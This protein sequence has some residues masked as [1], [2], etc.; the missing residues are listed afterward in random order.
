MSDPLADPRALELLAAHPDEVGMLAAHFR[1]AASESQATAT[2]LSAARQECTWIG[3]AADAFRRAIGRLPA[4]L[5]RVSAG[6]SEVAE[7]LT[8]YEAELFTITTE[9]KR[10][11][12]EL[13]DAES[14]LV[15]AK[16]AAP[17]RTPD[18]EPEVARLTRRAFALLDDF[19]SAREACR[20]A[21]A[22]AQAIAPPRPQAGN[23]ITVIG[24][25]GPGR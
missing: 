12:A 6:F 4:Q 10:T 23:G 9:F 22:A 21:I 17:A 5:D 19:S 15:A 11:V 25:S 7:A 24:A 8:A 1:A 18:T 2:G 3:R 20:S 13:A 14:R 16:A